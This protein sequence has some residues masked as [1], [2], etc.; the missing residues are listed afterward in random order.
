MKRAL[1]VGLLSMTFGLSAE[2]AQPSDRVVWRAVPAGVVTVGT[3]SG[4][5]DQRPAHQVRLPGFRV[6]LTEATV[7]QYRT[8]TRAGQCTTP[9]GHS[10]ASPESQRLNWGADGREEHPI[11]GIGWAQAKAFCAWAG[12]RLPTEA[13]WASAARGRH[14]P[15]ACFEPFVASTDHL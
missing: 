13:E 4:R 6:M 8:C 7:A 10:P 9:R 14:P 5:P 11:N 12:G 15:G 1:C 2:A 3:E